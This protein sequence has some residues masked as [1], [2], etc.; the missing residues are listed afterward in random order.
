MISKNEMW[1]ADWVVQ[2]K[3]DLR[4]TTYATSMHFWYSIIIK[5]YT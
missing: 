3:E 4:K 1:T 5:K 2:F